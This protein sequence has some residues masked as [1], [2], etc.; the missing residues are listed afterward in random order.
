MVVRVCQHCKK[1]FDFPKYRVAYGMGKFCSHACADNANRKPRAER[2]KRQ[3]KGCGK[4]FEIRKQELLNGSRKGVYCSMKC[5]NIERVTKTCP[6]CKNIFE[7]TI[8]NDKIYCS[9]SCANNSVIRNE[10]IGKRQ[11]EL[12]QEPAFRERFLSWIKERTAS[13]K[14]RDSAHFQKGDKH[15][16]YKGNASER[17]SAMGGYK[18]KKWRTDVFKRDNYT[19]QD[20]G[21]KG[22]Y[23][24]AHHLKEWAKYPELRYEITNGITL[25]IQCHKERHRSK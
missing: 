12:Q 18:Y 4:T 16:A 11:K 23:L 1:E 6:T 10:K 20:C 25:C 7:V 5:K 8:T 3:C 15:P 2:V 19:C 17:E 13:Q 9:K 14:W 22:G 24:H 21:N